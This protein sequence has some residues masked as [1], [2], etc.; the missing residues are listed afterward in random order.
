M[1]LSLVI[2]YPPQVITYNKWGGVASIGIEPDYIRGSI[3]LV[4]S[5]KQKEIDFFK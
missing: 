1:D 3:H 5:E 2:F 4:E